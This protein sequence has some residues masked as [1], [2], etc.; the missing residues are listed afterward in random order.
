MPEFDNLML[1]KAPVV[2]ARGTLASYSTF[3]CGR[4]EPK[5]GLF[6]RSFPVVMQVF[7]VLKLAVIT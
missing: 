1:L 6:S 7:K 2:A 5:I 3:T 4:L